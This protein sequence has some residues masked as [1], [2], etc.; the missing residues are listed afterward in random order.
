[1]PSHVP[2]AGHRPEPCATWPQLN[3]RDFQLSGGDAR[4]RLI[5]DGG[6]KA[7]HGLTVDGKRGLGTPPG[8]EEPQVVADRVG[9]EYRF[10]GLSLLAPPF[11]AMNRSGVV[12]VAA[13]LVVVLDVDRWAATIVETRIGGRIALA[14][15]TKRRP[16]LAPEARSA[17]ENAPRGPVRAPF[18]NVGETAPPTRLG[19]IWNHCRFSDVA[20]APPAICRKPV[21]EPIENGGKPLT[22]KLIPVLAVRRKNKNPNDMVYFPEY[23]FW[24]VPATP[25][26][27]W[28]A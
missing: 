4:K 27:L 5:A 11:C 20:G 23:P 17:F 8:T 14:L 3:D 15:A 6:E 19:T 12:I 9:E 18:S 28:S 26:P 24:A 10:G 2:R 21:F 22:S 1:M 16:G 25:A 7:F 13:S